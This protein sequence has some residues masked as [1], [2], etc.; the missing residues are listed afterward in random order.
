LKK[1]PMDHFVMVTPH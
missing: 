1:Y